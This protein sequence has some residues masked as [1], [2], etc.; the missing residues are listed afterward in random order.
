MGTPWPRRFCIGLCIVAFCHP[1]FSAQTDEKNKPTPAIE[2]AADD[3]SRVGS[4]EAGLTLPN[5]VESKTLEKNSVS[6]A[7]ASPDEAQESPSDRTDSQ[8]TDQL[9]IDDETPQFLSLIH[10]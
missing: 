6:D 3:S 5:P 7:K 10:I 4:P 1:A 2:T 8:L 9:T